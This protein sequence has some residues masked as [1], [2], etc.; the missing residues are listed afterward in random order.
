MNLALVM[1]VSTLDWA[2]VVPAWISMILGALFLIMALVSC[3]MLIVDALR[4]EKPVLSATKYDPI[5]VPEHILNAQELDAKQQPKRLIPAQ[6]APPQTIYPRIDPPFQS[7]GR[8]V[9][10]PTLWGVLLV[11]L[12]GGM[13]LIQNAVNVFDDHSVIQGFPSNPPA[14]DHLTINNP[15]VN[16]P[17]VNS[18]TIKTADGAKPQPD[19]SAPKPPKD[20]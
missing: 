2:P 18:P 13:M 19:Q 4:S 3:G 11:G 12:I 7:S 1:L 9:N 20:K 17:I 16:S 5:N 10:R 14:L 15:I 8:D 6:V